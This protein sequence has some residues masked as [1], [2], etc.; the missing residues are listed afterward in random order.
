M[1]L[2]SLFLRPKNLNMTEAFSYY[3]LLQ[4]FIEDYAPKVI[5]ATL[6]LI[7]G[8]WMTSW[9]TRLVRKGMGQ[10][11]FDISLQSFLSSMVNVVLKI[12]LLVTVAGMLGIQ[13]TSFVAILGAAGLAVG[14]ALQGSLSNFAGGVLTLVF[15][16]YKVG[17][18]IEAQGQTGIVKEIQIFNTI[19]LTSDHKTVIL[20]NGAV[21]NGTIVNHSRH[22][23]VRVEI[24]LALDGNNDVSK[25]RSIV[26][27][28]CKLNEHT[29]DELKSEVYVQQVKDGDLVIMIHT[30]T[31]SEKYWACYYSLMESIKI[32]FDREKIE[33]AQPPQ[34]AAVK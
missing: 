13:T 19:L 17:D 31:E 8:F 11:G 26:Q 1:V 27:E 2:P 32:N 15:K 34:F 9:M 6:V 16:P 24:S 12:M 21:S 29:I 30:F 28:I 20:P 7:V 25:V 22:G 23:D 10:R 14:L 33:F 5:G 18:K 4:N 3:R